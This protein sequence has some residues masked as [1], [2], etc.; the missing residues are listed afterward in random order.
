MTSHVQC[1]IP[2][3]GKKMTKIPV[4][5]KSARHDGATVSSVSSVPTAILPKRPTKRA[6][7]P[8]A[9]KSAA[10]APAAA[11]AIANVEPP[12]EPTGVNP[13]DIL[14]KVEGVSKD[15]NH[16]KEIVASDSMELKNIVN[17]L[18]LSNVGQSKDL[19]GKTMNHL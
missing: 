17:K 8:A 4:S 13:C 18:A 19:E 15:V 14:R 16:L 2:G 6:V 10:V 11:P 1:K 3:V 12:V 7:V 9:E 5:V